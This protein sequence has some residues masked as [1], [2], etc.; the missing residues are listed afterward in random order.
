MFSG[1][2]KTTYTCPVGHLGKNK[3]LAFLNIATRRPWPYMHLYCSNCVQWVD[4]CEIFL[5]PEFQHLELQPYEHP[6]CLGFSKPSQTHK[7]QMHCISSC[8]LSP[9]TPSFSGLSLWSWTKFT[10]LPTR[11]EWQLQHITVPWA[12][13]KPE[14]TGSGTAACFVLVAQIKQKQDKLSNNLS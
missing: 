10:A 7:P 4:K 2:E 8:H 3:P 14:V 9:P 6:E 1:R 13:G 12:G 11:W 5:P